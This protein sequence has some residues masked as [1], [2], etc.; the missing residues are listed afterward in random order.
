MTNIFET[1]VS[2]A[3]RNQDGTSLPGPITS[4]HQLSLITMNFDSN[5]NTKIRQY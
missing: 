3:F 5:L 1:Y 2:T 4:Q